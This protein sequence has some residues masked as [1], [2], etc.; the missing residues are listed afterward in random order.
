MLRMPLT[1]N[2]WRQFPMPCPQCAGA[3]GVPVS[4]QSKT[5]AEVIVNLRCRQCAHEWSIYRA[6][7]TLRP[8]RRREDDVTEIEDR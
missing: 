4:V 3:S 1:E 6:T 5:T 8:D 2:D 7:P